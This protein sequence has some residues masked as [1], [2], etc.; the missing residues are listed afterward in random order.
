MVGRL[1]PARNGAVYFAHEYGGLNKDRQVFRRNSFQQ[2][3]SSGAPDRGK[4]EV[5]Q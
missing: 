4:D 2:R 5:G 3:E 1:N